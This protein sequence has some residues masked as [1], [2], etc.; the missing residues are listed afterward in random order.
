MEARGLKTDGS[1]QDGLAPAH[2][3]MNPKPHYPLSLLTLNPKPY[4]LNP[5]APES[6]KWWPM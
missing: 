4:T 1:A 3:P 6:E 2:T 5:K